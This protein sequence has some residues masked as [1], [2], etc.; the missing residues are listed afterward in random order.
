MQSTIVTLPP[1]LCSPQDV[2]SSAPAPHAPMSIAIVTKASSRLIMLV[3][4][5]AGEAV[6]GVH[7]SLWFVDRQVITA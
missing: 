3:G 6:P 2:E 1:R 4:R 5:H 7:G